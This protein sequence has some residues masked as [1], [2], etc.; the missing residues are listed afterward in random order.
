M[1]GG[2]GLARSAAAFAVGPH[3]TSCVH[4]LLLRHLPQPPRCLP[5]R[6]PRG[7][8]AC[9]TGG[10]AWDDRL[11]PELPCC[12]EAR[13]TVHNAVPKDTFGGGFAPW[14]M[15]SGL[16]RGKAAIF[17][18]HI[19]GAGFGP[20][21]FWL[22][23]SSSCSGRHCR[24]LFSHVSLNGRLEL[25]GTLFFDDAVGDHT[26]GECKHRLVNE[27]NDLFIHRPGPG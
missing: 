26:G 10:W 15:V 1:G 23:R 20:G 12:W 22:L 6:H 25:L 14:S 17:V 4:Y 11:A 27:V 7:R 2:G 13:V 9:P 5:E 21:S 24:D 16:T 19:A 18:A 3:T 8:A